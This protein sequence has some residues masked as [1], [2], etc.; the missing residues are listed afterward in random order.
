MSR[1]VLSVI[2]AWT[3][4][5]A[6]A[7]TRPVSLQDYLVRSAD[8]LFVPFVVAAGAMLVSVWAGALVVRGVAIA[9]TTGARSPATGA[10]W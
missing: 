7:Q 3:A 6:A 10:R 8:G 1:V 5:G 4:A 2:F 9:L